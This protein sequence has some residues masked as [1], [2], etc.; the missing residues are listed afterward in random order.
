MMKPNI[1]LYSPSRVSKDF[2]KFY[3]DEVTSI[4]NYITTEKREG[5]IEFTTTSPEDND[6]LFIFEYDMT[7]NQGLSDE[8]I[9]QIK[10]TEKAYLA[11]RDL[12]TS[13]DFMRAL[14]HLDKSVGEICLCI[15]DDDKENDKKYRYWLTLNPE[16]GSRDLW[17]YEIGNFPASDIRVRFS[18]TKS[19][20]DDPEGWFFNSVPEAYKFMLERMGTYKKLDIDITTNLSSK[21]NFG[22]NYPNPYRLCE[23]GYPVGSQGYA[24]KKYLQKYIK[25]HKIDVRFKKM[26]KVPVTRTYKDGHKEIEEYSNIALSKDAFT[27]FAKGYV[28]KHKTESEKLWQPDACTFELSFDPK[29]IK[30]L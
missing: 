30:E 4:I 18:T 9:K 20:K 19:V 22:F 12:R 24:N 25:E 6:A 27:G 10:D 26:Y 1:K 23:E 2:V 17:R 11:N 8:E 3:K 29:E 14:S 21:V 15:V 13:Y 5:N 28:E 7:L 16:M